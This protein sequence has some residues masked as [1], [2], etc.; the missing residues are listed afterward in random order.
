MKNVSHDF[1]PRVTAPL[2][3]AF[4]VAA[5]LLGVLPSQARAADTCP[6]LEVPPFV[7]QQIV[8]EADQGIDALRGFVT[9]TEPQYQLDMND[10]VAWLDARRDGSCR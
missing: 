6:S 7:E 8:A 3:T 9:I 4:A 1:S 2:A 5:L 10:V